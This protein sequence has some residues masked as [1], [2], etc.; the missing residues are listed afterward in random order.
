MPNQILIIGGLHG[1]EPLGVS[2]VNYFQQNPV[3]GITAIYG[4]PEAIKLNTRFKN[5]DLNRVFPGV[6]SSNIY[7]EQ[8][9]FEIM[10]MAQGYSIVIDFHNTHC[11]NNDCGF[12]G[13]EQY[14]KALNAAT[15]LGLD[16]V[17]IADY[18]CVNKYIQNC[19]SVEISL[20]STQND[21]QTWV[22]R[23]ASLRNE[24]LTKNQEQPQLYQFVGRI[25]KE[26]MSE[27]NAKQW[28]AFKE[29]PETVTKQLNIPEKKVNPIFILDQYTPQSVCGLVRRLDG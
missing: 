29:L 20:S 24:D 27:D 10:K 18:D 4:N 15:L 19:L 8:R 21:L 6:E 1:N 2:V 9:A 22:R 28:Q 13:G 12:V 11:P 7:E 5:R 14:T 16:K 26:D 25:T 3:N 23:I 17:I